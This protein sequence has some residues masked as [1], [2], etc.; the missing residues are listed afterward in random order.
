MLGL[1]Y[2]VTSTDTAEILDEAFVHVP[3]A[4]AESLAAEKAYAARR[5]GASGLVL[6]FDTIVVHGGELL[7]KPIDADDARRMLHSLSG[8]THEVVT[9]VAILLP[10]ADEARTFA[11]T[12][13][14]R[15]RR[16]TDDDIDRWFAKGEYLGC[17]GAYNI[18]SHLAEVD[19]D[20]CFQNVAGLP[21]CHLYVAM[22]SPEVAQHT[23]APECPVMPCDRVRSAR[24]ALGP[25][26][27]AGTGCDPG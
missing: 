1:G 7:G 3:G 23:A 11:V 26:L 25:R 12:T 18:E 16:L 19:A 10:M 22:H 6:S 14:V 15:M 5:E 17:A 9:G 20:Q 13:P 8:G 4:L 27:V 2:A 21:L 24:C